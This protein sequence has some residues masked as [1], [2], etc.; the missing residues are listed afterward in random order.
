MKITASKEEVAIWIAHYNGLVAD[1][2]ANEEAADKANRKIQDLEAQVWEST[3]AVSGINAKY[4]D[5][6]VRYNALQQ[7]Q[8]SLT[9][10]N[11][12][13][14]LSDLCK[15]FV[16]GDKSAA[17]RLVRQHTGLSLK[18][19]KAL[20]EGNNPEATPSKGTLDLV[21]RWQE[22]VKAD[23]ARTGNKQVPL[24]PPKKEPEQ[25][26]DR[27]KKPIKAGD[28]VYFL[29]CDTPSAFMKWVPGTIQSID[30]QDICVVHQH[31]GEV[32]H[33]PPNLIIY[34]GYAS[35]F[36]ILPEKP[37]IAE[38]TELDPKT[39]P[40]S[41]K[42]ELAKD[43]HGLAKDSHGDVL[44]IGDEVWFSN[45]G[46][47]DY[48]KWRIGTIH[49][50]SPINHVVTLKV[51]GENDIEYKKFSSQVFLA[52][53]SGDQSKI[54]RDNASVQ[55]QDEKPKENIVY[56]TMRDM[57]GDTIELNSKVW[58]QPKGI[59]NKTQ[60]ELPW[61]DGTVD[62]RFPPD[63]IKVR[64]GGI[65]Y[66]RHPSS[67]SLKDPNEGIDT[68]NEVDPILSNLQQELG[69]LEK[70]ATGEIDK[71]VPSNETP[72]EE[73]QKEAVKEAFDLQGC[74][75]RVGNRVDFR[76]HNETN[77]QPRFGTIDKIDPNSTI[78]NGVTLIIRA[79]GDSNATHYR[80]AS[81]VLLDVRDRQNWPLKVGDRV[82]FGNGSTGG[83]KIGT[84]QSITTF[85]NTVP[86]LVIKA[87]GS[88]DPHFRRPDFVTNI[89]KWEKYY[90]NVS[91]P[92]TGEK[93]EIIKEARDYLG[94]PLKVGDKVD[95]T[96]SLSA[97][98][99][100]IESINPVAKETDEV[101]VSIKVE[102]EPN[103][104]HY[105][106]ARELSRYDNVSKVRDLHWNLLK[107]GDKV[108]FRGYQAF[109][110]DKEGIIE[111]INP[112]SKV[113]NAITA[114][115]S[116]VGEKTRYERYV[117]E[118]IKIEEFLRADSLTA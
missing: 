20:V 111:S 4:D 16:N 70:I 104:T 47:T 73:P 107:V 103:V 22:Q 75:L 106:K 108:R 7:A 105:R 24:L 34:T 28:H 41:E 98:T 60:A 72:K 32:H 77:S 83:S 6:L 62:A 61:F 27:N 81:E 69:I 9:G 68:A 13:L 76:N 33:R 5:L 29:E 113:R 99:G 11:L 54:R 84:I 74:R 18:Q 79:D 23:E 12:V 2:A 116:V 78:T 90:P 97:K 85:D 57:H 115:I 44:R 50:I 36:S 96:V 87:D 10:G 35:P 43:T 118:I 59:K 51:A 46:T 26:L 93:K 52:G 42:D 95:F 39:E 19:S 58:F 64:S 102:D 82:D 92:T 66:D 100:T 112:I 86:L 91:S 63:I 30:G 71:V 3:T 114:T 88:E 25:I 110:Y 49:S 38:V 94:N 48:H 45:G 31:T 56:Q 55:K 117:A 101:F 37:V 15:A 14:I 40:K 65:I 1:S 109:S 89:N 67:V 53:G 80:M 21:K 17:V 8:A